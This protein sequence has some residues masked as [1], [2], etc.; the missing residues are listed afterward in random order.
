MMLPM[1]TVTTIGDLPDDYEQGHHDASA[2][3]WDDYWGRILEFEI[4]G[5]TRT[6]EQA[7]EYGRRWVC[8]LARGIEQINVTIERAG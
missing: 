1:W 4:A 7:T 3:A 2:R 6:D 5:Y 8:H